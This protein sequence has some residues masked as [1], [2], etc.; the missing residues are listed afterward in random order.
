MSMPDTVACTPLSPAAVLAVCV[1]WPLLS[2]GDL[3]SSGFSVERASLSYQRAP[4]TLL[5][6]RA[7]SAVPKSQAPLNFAA[8]T[9]ASGR[10]SGSDAKLGLS[11]Q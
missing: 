8:I 10:G 2:R 6:Q 11:G 5:L 4:I 7:G 3:N 9:R 1:P